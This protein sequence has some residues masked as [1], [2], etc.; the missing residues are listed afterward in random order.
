MSVSSFKELR[1][2]V[3]HKLV[4]SLYKM[5]DGEECNVAIECETCMEILLD[6]DNPEVFNMNEC[7]QCGT[8]SI[9]KLYNESVMVCEECDYEWMVERIRDRDE[10]EVANLMY[11]KSIIKKL[12]GLDN[13]TNL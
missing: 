9:R 4:V 10:R 12:R 13:P 7:P 8:S 1:D 6:F 5:E 11:F 3:G 2:H